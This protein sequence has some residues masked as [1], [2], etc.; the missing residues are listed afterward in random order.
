MV[1]EPDRFYRFSRTTT[2]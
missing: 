1:S 2:S